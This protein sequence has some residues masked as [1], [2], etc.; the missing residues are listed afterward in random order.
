M[1]QDNEQQNNGASREN[2]SDEMSFAQMFD[3]DEATQ[4]ILS[5]GQKVSAEIVRI[6]KEWI[7]IDLGGK[8]EGSLASSEFLDEEGN[9]MVK[10]GDFIEVYFL[11]AK[12]NGKIFTTKIGG[13]AATAHLEEAF[14]GSIP[15]EATIQKEIKGGFEIKIGSSVRAFCPFSQIGLRRVADTDQYIG[16]SLSFKIVEFKENGKNIIVSHRKILEEERV[17]KKEALKETLEVGQTVE[18]TITSVRDFGA[19]VDID[20]IEGL[21]P[22]SEISWGRTN[23]IH[24]EVEEGQQVKVAVKKLDWDN[25]RY[26]FSL[27]ETLPDPWDVCSLQEGTTVSGT[28]ARLAD[29]GAFVTLAPGIDGLVHISKLGAG[30]RINHPREVVKEGEVVEIRIDSIELDKKRISLSI[31]LSEE[32]QSRQK[33]KK[34]KDDQ[35]DDMRQEFQQ[36]K[37]SGGEKRSA[38]GTFADLLKGK[39]GGGM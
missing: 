6:T 35:P 39:T 22:I 23:D 26:S 7:F 12:Q 5:P 34:K 11:A 10:E 33:K 27:R 17:E 1:S 9:P 2:G 8:S 31:P 37:K 20:G 25:D 36:F 4:D 18:G 29:F 38:M 21:I 24:A 16:Q 32:A 14:R 15:V 3:Q 13:A 28:V 30:R 19:F